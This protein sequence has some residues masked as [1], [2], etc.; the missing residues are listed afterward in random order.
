MS[1]TWLTM[2]AFGAGITT[3]TGPCI[4]PRFLAAVTLCAGTS[5]AR[6]WLRLGSFVAGSALSFVAACSAGSAIARI[7]AYSVQTY[8]VLATVCVIAGIAGIV[9]THEC[10]NGRTSP[11]CGAAFLGGGAA[12]IVGAPCCGPLAALAGA[13][14]AMAGR[15]PL[16]PAAF[17][18]GHA[19]PFV[20]LAVGSSARIDRLLR[21]RWPVEAS[22]T[23]AGGLAVALG[24]YYAVLA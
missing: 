9:R 17:A 12:G 14:W 7:G 5:G 20:A 22:A 21:L 23:I 1:G 8:A 3:S 16:V 11:S 24:A 4:A 18:L 6:R 15:D 19:V 13:G 10:A 2:A